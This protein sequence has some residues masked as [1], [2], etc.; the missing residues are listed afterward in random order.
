VVCQE[1]TLALR[2]S[3]NSTA[4]PN[5]A[6]HHRPR[7]HRRPVTRTAAA[8][9]S[10]PMHRR[11]LVEFAVACLLLT[12]VPWALLGVLDANLEDGPGVLVFALAASGPSLAAR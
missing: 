5:E 4:A 9:E 2:A 6:E 10:V 11:Q 8:G 1:P 7:D 12:W 3:T